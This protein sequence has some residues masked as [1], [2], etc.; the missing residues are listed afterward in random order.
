MS[1]TEK[2]NGF[3]LKPGTKIGGCCRIAGVIGSG[4]FGITYSGYD[5]R[6]RKPVAVKEYFP[7]P[8]AVRKGRRVCP[9]SQRSAEEYRVGLEKFCREGEC[10]SRFNGNPGIV[11]VFDCIRANNTAYLI[12]EYLPGIT[13]ESYVKKC[14]TLSEAQ[15]VTLADRLSAALT[16]IHSAGILHRDISPDNVMLCGDIIKLVDFGAA[17]STISETA[18]MLTVALKTG[19]TPAEQY[20]RGGNFGDWTDIY[21]LG[22][23]LYFALTGKAPPPPYL[24]MMDD[25]EFSENVSAVGEPLRGVIR[26]A[27]GISER[28]RYA[29]SAEMKREISVLQMKSEPIPVPKE[30]LTEPPDWKACAPGPGRKILAA[31]GA[32]LLTAALILAVNNIPPGIVSDDPVTLNFGGEYAGDYEYQGEI[33]VSRLKRFGGDVKI[34]VQY[35][36]CG[37]SLTEGMPL[38]FVPADEN[39]TNMIGWLFNDY[40][41]WADENG[42][43]FL[44]PDYRDYSFTI[45]R[46]GIENITG[47]SF[48]FE[49][50]NIRI[51]SVTLEKGDRTG[52][53]R[54][55][56]RDYS[57]FNEEYRMTEENGRRIVSVEMGM[58]PDPEADGGRINRASVPK[59]AFLEFDGDVRMTL[60]V[61]RFGTE[62]MVQLHIWNNGGLWQILDGKIS[63][64]EAVDRKNARI[65][66][67]MEDNGWI[68][69]CGGLTECSVIVSRKAV[70]RMSG[71]IFFMGLHLSVKSVR[72]EDY[73][74]EE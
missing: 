7:D 31:A 2:N 13:L 26:K 39:G 45:S 8:G 21:S 58:K 3:A 1:L 24:R 22:A 53:N 34:T 5:V 41:P 59:A 70:E 51:Q 63:A 11:S 43:I 35:E 42:W 74:G 48:G 40:D 15:T 61:E 47:N 60:E 14:G 33:P 16:V 10:V 55:Y 28:E 72:L 62:D 52:A 36:P 17:R 38:G 56:F 32:V 6:S 64:E 66:L 20:T 29:N 65:L 54:Y 9:S 23:V 50:Y 30:L 44:N 73:E 71:G 57:E 69:L 68:N 25:G 27:M 12:M 46:E 18:P 19:F 67:N 4:G 49:T 37:T